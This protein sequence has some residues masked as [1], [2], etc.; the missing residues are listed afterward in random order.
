MILIYPWIP[1]KAGDMVPQKLALSSWAKQN[2]SGVWEAEELVGDVGL[3][4][5]TNDAANKH[6]ELEF[7]QDVHNLKQSWLLSF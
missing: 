2:C 6:S 4:S 3:A 1:W 5:D 7:Y